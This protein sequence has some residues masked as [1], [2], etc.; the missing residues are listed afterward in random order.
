MKRQKAEIKMASSISAPPIAAARPRDLEPSL[1]RIARELE[2]LRDALRLLGL[3]QCGSCGKY[4]QAAD[5]KAL[6]ELGQ[7]VCYGCVQEWW[8]IRSPLLSVQDRLAAEHKLLRWL[9]AHHNGKVI[10]QSAKARH[11]AELELSIVAGCEQCQATGKTET[12]GECRNCEGC[13]SVKVI[14]LRPEFR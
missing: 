13:G 4:Y 11:P 3:K 12:G 6:L 8:S 1:T 7:L 9:V 14:V 5:G 2:N 10:R